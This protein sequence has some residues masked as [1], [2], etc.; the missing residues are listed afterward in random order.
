MLFSKK[1]TKKLISTVKMLELRV[2]FQSCKTDNNVKA[3]SLDDSLANI[4]K[5]LRLKYRDFFDIDKAEQQ[6]PHQSTDHAIKLKPGFEP[7]YI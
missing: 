3:V 2:I 5:Q 1:F 6:P 4:P 7:P